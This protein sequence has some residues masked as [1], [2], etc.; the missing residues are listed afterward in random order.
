MNRF[1]A[2]DTSK[3]RE[4]PHKINSEKSGK[5]VQVLV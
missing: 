1:S 3:A 5:P 2:R 4:F